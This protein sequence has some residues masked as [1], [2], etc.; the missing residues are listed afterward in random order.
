MSSNIIRKDIQINLKNLVT[1]GA[2]FIG[3]NIINN[4]MNRGEKVICI[5][6]FSTGSINNIKKWISHPNFIFIE[7]DILK[8]IN[9]KS[10]RIWHFACP[11]SPLHYQSDPIKTLEVSFIGSKNML[12]LAKKNNSKILLAS[13]SEIYGDAKNHSQ[14]ESYKGSVNTISKRGCYVE[15]KRVAETLFYDYYRIYKIDIKI[16]RIFNTYGPNMLQNDGR[17][18]SNFIWQALNNKPITIY[19]EGNQ[20][21]SFCFIDDLIN[22]L[23]K[24][25]ISNIMGPINIGNDKEEYTIKDLAYIIREK[26]NPLIK[27]KNYS[28]PQDDP[29]RRKPVIDYARKILKW[30]PTISLKDGLDKTIDYFKK[31]N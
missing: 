12:D 30:E 14:I 27:F 6:N 4:L 18:I 13:S 26:I 19:G 7:H 9:V 25:M 23:D 29:F 31:L 15:G 16:A 17:V 2:G 24:L 10:D 8:P 22:G 20:T 1:G 21:R 5:D 28:L 11:A 3:S